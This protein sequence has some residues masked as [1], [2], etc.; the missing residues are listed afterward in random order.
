MQLP[1]LG[2]QHCELLRCVAVALLS[3]CQLI[4][5]WDI[6]AGWLLR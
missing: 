5:F 2:N 3:G 6:A 4:I 1:I